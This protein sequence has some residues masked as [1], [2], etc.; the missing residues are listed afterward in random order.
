MNRCVPSPSD[1]ALPFGRSLCIRVGL[2]V[3]GIYYALGAV[4]VLVVLGF[5][6]VTPEG[7]QGRLLI[8]CAVRNSMIGLICACALVL[9]WFDARIAPLI[10]VIACGLAGMFALRSVASEL[11]QHEQFCAILDGVILCISAATI[12]VSVRGNSRSRSRG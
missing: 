2:G 8:S 6:D 11:L 1:K 12:F 5:G 3:C 10:T 4:A 9:V 7:Q